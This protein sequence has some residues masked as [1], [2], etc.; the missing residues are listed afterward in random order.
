VACL[1]AFIQPKRKQQTSGYE[2]QL[3]EELEDY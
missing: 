3:K 2:K 1:I